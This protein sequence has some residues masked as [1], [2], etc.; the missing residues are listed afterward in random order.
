MNSLPGSSTDS[1]RQNTRFSKIATF[2]TLAALFAT[3]GGLFLKVKYN[4]DAKVAQLR[5]TL[6]RLEKENALSDDF[7]QILEAC[8]TM[9]ENTN[10]ATLKIAVG[11]AIREILGGEIVADDRRQELLFAMQECAEL[12][13]LME[14]LKVDNKIASAP[15]FDLEGLSKEYLRYFSAL[16]E[17]QPGELIGVQETTLNKLS[18]SL[19]QLTELLDKMETGVNLSEKQR[20]QIGNLR[21][22]IEN[23]KFCVEDFKKQEPLTP[24]SP[25]PND[26]RR[27]YIKY[28]QLGANFAT[29]RD[30]PR[31]P[32][33]SERRQSFHRRIMKI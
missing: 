13:D 21:L 5:S 11:E 8:S 10:L 7:N 33:T 32:T 30:A 27:L 14:Q 1:P 9:S 28:N 24:K 4:A 22:I 26:N 16:C 6:D 15:G 20:T 2:G 17:T 18:A 25:G 19:K 12:I 3:G 23:L 31:S 29:P